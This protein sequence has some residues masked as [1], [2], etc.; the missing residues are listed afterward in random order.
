LAAAEQG[1]E[2]AEQQLKVLGMPNMPPKD[3]WPGTTF[4]VTLP[5]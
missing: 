5:K 3:H 2:A 4:C 1:S